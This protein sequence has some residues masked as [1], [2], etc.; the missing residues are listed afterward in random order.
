MPCWDNYERGKERCVIHFASVRLAPTNSLRVRIFSLSCSLQL[1][2]LP[3]DRLSALE[4][5]IGDGKDFEGE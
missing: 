3:Q 1:N 5:H 4:I 2:T